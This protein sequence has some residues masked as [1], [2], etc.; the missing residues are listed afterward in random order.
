[1]KLLGVLIDDNLSF[2]K[3]ISNLC[4]NAP[5]QTNASRMIVKYIPTEWRLNIMYIKHLYPQISNLVILCRIFCSN[6][7]TNEIDA[8]II[9]VVFL[10]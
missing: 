8:G 2:N 1:M 4:V 7:S 10:I 5:R 9:S 6:R 3:P